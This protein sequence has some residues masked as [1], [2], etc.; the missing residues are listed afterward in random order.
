MNMGAS[1]VAMNDFRSEPA[2]LL[3]AELSACER[4]LK[5]GWWI[6]G[7]EVAGF[8]RDWAAWLGLPH[9]V[10]CGNG[11]DA[12]ELGLRALGIGAGDEVITTPMTAFATVLAILRA[13]AVP[14]LADVD[15]GTAMLSPD[16]VR[17]CLTARVRAIL[18]VHLYGQVGPVDELG[19]IAR[20]HDLPLLE[21]C[22]QAHGAKLRGQAVGGFGA[23]GA[24]SFYPTKNLGAV[25]DAGALTTA[26]GDLADKVRSLRNYGQSVRYHHPLIGMNSRLDELQAA[27]LQARLTFLEQWIAARRA[28]AQ[29]YAGAI[30]NE[31]VRV[32]P[33]PAERDRHAYHLFVLTTSHR[34]RLQ[35][36]LSSRGIESL[37]HY[38]T[39]VHRQPPCEDL[40]RDPAGLPQCE[41]HADECLS[42]PCRPGLSDDDVDRV[43]DAVNTF[44]L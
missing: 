5:S 3:A 33:M 23:F 32:L 10:G 41:R 14:V 7:Q 22:A 31:W 6:L 28:V 35:A 30:G 19:A 18:L 29:R 11:L 42:L 26:S 34:E 36:H 39:P 37:I 15:P 2:A 44:R 13:G 38:P 21:D 43:I 40:R 8:E 9:A 4:V 17:R 1:R 24:W 25:G 20:E 16:S 27:L 12:I